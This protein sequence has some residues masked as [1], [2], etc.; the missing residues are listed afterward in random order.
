M[1]KSHRELSEEVGSPRPLDKKEQRLVTELAQELN[2]IL[3]RLQL[4][5]NAQMLLLA[6]EGAADDAAALES[7]LPDHI[8]GDLAQLLV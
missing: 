4:G 1:E 6:A 7:Q 8:F 5:S 3:G 2:H